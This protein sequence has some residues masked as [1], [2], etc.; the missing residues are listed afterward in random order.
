MTN[1]EFEKWYKEACKRS[2][3]PNKKVWGYNDDFKW[4]PNVHGYA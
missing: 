3:W 4:M 1:S 2:I